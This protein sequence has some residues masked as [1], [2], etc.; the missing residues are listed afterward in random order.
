[1]NTDFVDPSNP[2]VISDSLGAAALNTAQLQQDNSAN[3][4]STFLANTNTQVDQYLTTTTDNAMFNQLYNDGRFVGDEL[5]NKKTKMGAA[6]AMAY[7]QVHSIRSNT[8][9]ADI[10]TGWCYVLVWI[11]QI[12]LVAVCAA[13]LLASTL[14]APRAKQA[15]ILVGIAYL[16][17][18]IASVSLAATRRNDRWSRFYWQQ[19]T[20]KSAS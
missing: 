15:V 13:V 8:A 10:R 2:R 20:N 11:L 18:L 16:S 12:S 5:S 4:A 19:Q 9:S 14:S 3:N 7:T 6:A 17:T 1:M